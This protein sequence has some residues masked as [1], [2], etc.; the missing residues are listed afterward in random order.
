MKLIHLPFE[1]ICLFHD[2]LTDTANF[3]HPGYY[4]IK[5]I[6][7]NFLSI[8]PAFLELRKTRGYF[9]LNHQ[10]TLQYYFD[11][12]IPQQQP[13]PRSTIT[14]TPLFDGDCAGCD[15]YYEFRQRILRRIENPSKQLRLNFKYTS[16]LRPQI[17]LILKFF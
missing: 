7:K 12:Y 14:T 9:S 17:L 1:I 11:T 8:H 15:G 6:W 5:G 4:T 10:A 2:Y 13:Q 3:T 16:N